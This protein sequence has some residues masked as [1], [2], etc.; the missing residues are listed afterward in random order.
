MRAFQRTAKVIRYS[1]PVL[2]AS[3]VA[4][5]GTALR[6][7]TFSQ[8]GEDQAILR[9]LGDKPG[10]YFDIGANHP[11][12]ASNSYLLYRRGWRGV[13]VEPLPS[14]VK[15]HRLVRRRDTTVCA[16]IGSEPGISTLYETRPTGFS[17]LD[18]SH[19]RA[20]QSERGVRVTERTVNILRAMDVWQEFMDVAPDFVSIDTE[21]AEL[22]VLASMDWNRQRPRL[23][24]V[25]TSREEGSS[26][27]S[28]LLEFAGTVCYEPLERFGV[29]LILRD[30]S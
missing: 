20:L 7:G 18:R 4:Y 9:L 16:A 29:N 28:T 22:D 1:S 26:S 10:T 14:L 6:K 23:M 5:L 30:S 24:A 8:F 21:G 19:A 13:T 15:L 3:D 27:E 12:K 25:E 11:F 2:R 17:T